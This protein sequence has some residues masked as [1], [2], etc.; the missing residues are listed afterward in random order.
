MHNKRPILCGVGRKTR[1][2]YGSILC[3]PIQPNT[4]SWLTQPN[5]RQVGK[6]G[7]KPTQPDTTN[8]GAYSLVA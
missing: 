4:I 1:V 7:H 8:N 5:P 3:D 6:F 2:V